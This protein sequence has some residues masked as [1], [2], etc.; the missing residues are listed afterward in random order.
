MKKVLCC[1]LLCSLPQYHCIF[2]FTLHSHVPISLSC[3][4]ENYSRHCLFPC[5][6]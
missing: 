1:S 2:F 6:S 3:V 4:K 5:F